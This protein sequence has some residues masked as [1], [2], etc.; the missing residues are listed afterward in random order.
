VAT[1]R[2]VYELI[3]EQLFASEKVKNVYY[4]QIGPALS[5]TAADLVDSYQSDFLT[6]LRACQ[7][8]SLVHT[9]IFARNLFDPAEFAEDLISLAGTLTGTT[10]ELPPF[11]AAGF[12]LERETGAT[13]NG[14]K[15]VAAGSE[16]HQDW[17]A[18]SGAFLS[19]FLDPIAV[20]LSDSLLSGVTQAFFPV[21]V[22]RILEGEKYRLPENLAEA[23]VNGVVDAIYS[24]LLTTQNSRKYTVGE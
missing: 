2:N 13:R 16:A 12:T 9:R 23:T 24:S 18:W 14:K 19:T 4:F 6:T 17:G 15:R 20:L 10:D 8:P 3:D 22:K 11:V 21:I 5:L 1:D 7:H